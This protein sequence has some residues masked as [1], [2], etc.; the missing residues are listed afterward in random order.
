MLLFGFPFN[1]VK[2]NLEIT[3]YDEFIVSSLVFNK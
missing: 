1:F 3:S 2:I